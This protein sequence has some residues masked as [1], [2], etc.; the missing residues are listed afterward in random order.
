MRSITSPS[1]RRS[2]A[3][4]LRRGEERGKVSGGVS[5]CGGAVHVGR[6]NLIHFSRAPARGRAGRPARIAW[7]RRARRPG[8][9]LVSSRSASWCACVPHAIVVRAEHCPR[10][11]Y[12]V[13]PGHSL[14]YAGK[15]SATGKQSL[16]FSPTRRRSL[17]ASI[18]PPSAES[19]LSLERAVVEMQRPPLWRGTSGA[20]DV[21][22][23]GVGVDTAG[24][25][26]CHS[27][28]APERSVEN[29]FSTWAPTFDPELE[30]ALDEALANVPIDTPVAARRAAGRPG[31]SRSPDDDPG[32]S[33]D[34]PTRRLGPLADL[35]PAP[36]P[37]PGA[38][39]AARRM[40]V[41]TPPSKRT[42]VRSGGPPACA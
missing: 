38:K 19:W 15:V 5:V 41:G 14:K 17:W 32:T 34:D 12:A 7:R 31:A 36:P 16:R 23:R 35:P 24:L 22:N 27:G 2:R 39:R 11:H 3:S 37:R 9:Y 10:L 21:E 40:L 8:S 42:R 4:S 13:H 25:E 30:A 18:S 29:T 28:R 26:A 20:M 33:V 6:G 1:T